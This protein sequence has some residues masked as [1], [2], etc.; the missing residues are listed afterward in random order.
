M[1]V[2]AALTVAN[3]L[4]VVFGAWQVQASNQALNGSGANTSSGAY[5]AGYVFTFLIWYV[6]L[7]GLWVWM[8]QA[9]RAGRNWARIT[10]TVF[11]GISCL[12][13]LG[14]LVVDSL[15]GSALVLVA[16]AVTCLSWIL[17]LF[18]VILLW[19][20]KSAAHFKS[21]PTPYSA[22]G[23]DFRR[24]VP[25][26]NATMDGIVQHQPLTDPWGAPDGQA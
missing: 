4:L 18:T 5:K 6:G 7:A 1:H 17:G 10:G 23:P 16:L 3:G 22:Y 21:K 8:A 26:P 19:H 2:G 20:K 15:A 24:P 11:F 14:N 9:S 12:I 25:N 13:V